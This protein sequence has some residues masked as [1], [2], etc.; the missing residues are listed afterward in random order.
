MTKNFFGCCVHMTAYA[1]M[2]LCAYNNQGTQTNIVTIMN[3]ENACVCK[4]VHV[5]TFS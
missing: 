2:P 5:C 4:C 1:I 3:T